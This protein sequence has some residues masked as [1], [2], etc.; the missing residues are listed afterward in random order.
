VRLKEPY[1]HYR[2]V[3]CKRECLGVAPVAGKLNYINIIDEESVT[4][5]EFTDAHE[6]NKQRRMTFS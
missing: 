1:S 2:N 6:A 3:K 4:C 5:N